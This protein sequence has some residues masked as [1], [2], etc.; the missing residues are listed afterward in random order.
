MARHCCRP[1]IMR[2]RGTAHRIVVS[3]W[4]GGNTWKAVEEMEEGHRK[5]I[6]KNSK[7]EGKKKERRRK[8]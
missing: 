8:R 6:S 7:R 4:L 3:T 2:V 5:I 1:M